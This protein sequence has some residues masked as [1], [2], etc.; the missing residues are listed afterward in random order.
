LSDEGSGEVATRVEAAVLDTD[1]VITRTA[2][3]HFGAWKRLFDDVLQSPLAEGAHDRSPFTDD[4]Y[5]RFV[6]GMAR[7]DGVARF[8]ASRGIDLPRGD[9]ADGP[10]EAT[11][12]GLGNRK[13]EAFLAELETHGVQPFAGTVRFVEA[14]RAQGIATAAI[15]ASENCEAV[16]RQ[17]GVD[18][19]FDVRVDGLDAARLGLP[20]KPDPAVFLEAAARLGVAPDHALVVEDAVAGVE[21]GRAGGFG[22]VVGVDRTSHPESLAAAHL[23]V[24]DLADLE[25]VGGSIGAA[26][27][28]R[29]PLVDLTSALGDPDVGR[30]LAQRPAAVFLDYDGTLTPI[31]ARPELAV[32]GDK[33]RAV[34]A[35]LAEQC[36]VA[37]LSGRDLPDV[38][39]LVDVDGLWYGGSHGLELLGPEGQHHEAEGAAEIEPV[40]RSAAARLAPLV[41]EV[42]GAWVE[43]K[44]F[45]LAVHHR[46]SPEDQVPRLREIVDSVVDE[47]HGVHASGGS[48]VFEI[49]PDLAWD[50]GR[51]LAFVME[52][53]GAHPPGVL[54]VY[55]GDDVTDED[56]FLAVRA[57]GLGIVVG[58][59][60][61]E[62]AALHRLDGP[63]EVRQLLSRLADEQE[64]T[65][66]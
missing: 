11:V 66:K 5:R 2:A 64:G 27:R 17:A 39:G 18:H 30:R 40:L 35:R 49:R 38:R 46:A 45:A 43:E 16:L 12:C 28:P 41:A 1:G 57:E 58:G 37:I 10:G 60:L 50:K 23:V 61:A 52:V 14:L 22:L 7:Y 21:A 24:P 53:T 42:P 59:E 56:A 55:I 3:V 34:L 4:D 48:K 8:L 20:G 65:A 26:A 54:P 9:P 29:Q 36:T 51:A 31:V 33:T 15:S 32:L 25:V 63:D 19:L 13:N 44:R 62:T 6:D 47:S